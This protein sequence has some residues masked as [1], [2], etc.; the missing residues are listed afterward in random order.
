MDRWLTEIRQSMR[1]LLRTPAFSLAVVVT[2]ALGIGVA[3]AVYSLVYAILLRPYTY[4]DP[5][6]LVRVQSRHLKQGGALQGCSLADIEDYRRHAT[7]IEGVGAFYAFDTQI[8]SDGRPDVVTITQLN[9]AAIDILGVKPV[10][11]RPLK[12]EEDLPGGDVHKAVISYSLWQTRFASDPHVVG[13]ALRTQ[14]VTYTIVGVMPAGFGFPQRTAF[15]TPMESFYAML[16][17]ERKTKPRDSRFY[18]TIAK[19][20]PGVTLEQAD[21]DLN[22]VAAALEREYPKLNEGVRVKLTPLREFE[23]GSLR[24][25]LQ[26][27]TSGVALVLL[28]CCANVAGLLLVRATARQRSLAIQAALGASRARIAQALLIESAMLALAGGLLGVGL[29]HLGVKVVVSLI[30][31][32]LPL[33]LQIAIDRSVLAFSLAATIATGAGFGLAPALHMSRVDVTAALNQGARGS[34]MRGRLRLGLIVTEV[35]LSLLLLVFAALLVQA[36]A[37]L[38]G[39]DKGFEAGGLL[40]ARVVKYQGGTRAEASAVLG[41]MHLR[42]LDHLRRIPGVASA[43]VTNTLPFTGTQVDRGRTTLSIRGRSQEETK[44]SAPYT[45]GDVSPDYFRTMR[46]RLLRGRLFEDSDT[47]TSP[48]V[49]VIN[50]RAARLLSP[51]R[52]PIGQELL[53]GSLS[54]ANPYCRIVGIVE[55]VRHQAAESEDGIEFYY[56]ITQWP[57]S[58]SY[59]VVRT[60][61]DP[62]ALAATV[63][64]TIESA[65]PTVAVTVVKTMERRIDESLWQERLWG[66]M[67]SVFAALAVLLAAV[68]LY[69]LMAHAVA[70]RTREIGIRIAL[71]ARQASVGRMIVGEALTL[72]GAGVVV[73]AVAALAASRVIRGLLHGVPPHDPATYF[74]VGGVLCV[75][76]LAAA[77]I[78]ALRATRVDPIRALRSE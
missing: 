69:G 66:V 52:D 10:V 12:A 46:I 47:A 1:S 8:L 38:H 73:G 5:E 43:A 64:R 56:P 72:V 65:E 29:A 60:D 32:S 67:F 24:P 76:G 57:I 7:T 2:T 40:T 21:A 13:Q 68:G 33:W 17:P 61:G 35:A 49:M 6:R 15:W 54:P 42:V 36:F 74:V 19:L 28:I 45:G 59:Y 27:L 34:V 18:A 41:P 20:K 44:I 48:F 11:G 58:N 70:Q 23:V 62:E 55:N 78:P 14:L 77:W 31:I 25:Y 63:R 30:P 71:G 50:E 53:W 22:A 39:I 16:P 3:T 9:P 51:N 4:S 37:R 26:L 75:T